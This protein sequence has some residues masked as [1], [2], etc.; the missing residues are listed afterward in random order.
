MSNSIDLE[1]SLSH[2]SPRI[3]TLQELAKYVGGKVAG[4]LQVEVNGVQSFEAASSGDLT[5]AAESGY[6]EQLEKTQAAAVVVPRDIHSA[7]KSLLQVDQPKIA[8]ARIIELL[9][10][11]PFEAK[12]ISPLAYVDDSCQIAEKAT[13][14]PFAY[15]GKR[16]K[17][18]EGVTLFPGVCVGSDCVIGKG[19][20]L[21]SNVTLYDNV[22]LGDRVILHSGTVIGSDGFGYVFNGKEQVKILQT[23]TV[24]IGDDVEIGANSCV[25][26]AT[27]GST[28]LNKGVKLDNHVHIGHNCR[29]GENTVVVAQ[30][31]IS[32]SVEIGDNC[33]FAG[34]SG[35]SDH[36]KIGNEVKV[37]MKSAVSKDVPSYSI[38][39]GQPAMDH[40]KSMKIEALIRNLP[41]L[42]EEWKDFKSTLK[43]KPEK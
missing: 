19:C 6:Y 13:I 28:I 43:N 15:V 24:E 27:F 4:D 33:V 35:V 22:S 17:I 2:K 1:V 8:F 7:D 11:V 20:S 36:V 9:H 39:S 5:L 14:Y 3:Y 16:V 12:G 31:G 38:I 26:R 37:M 29:I 23:G 32:G 41:R 10:T 25:D 30:V 34:H 21:Y 40:R 18:S 42:Y